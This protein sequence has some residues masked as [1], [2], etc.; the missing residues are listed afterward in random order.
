MRTVEYLVALFMSLILV[1]NANAQIV[2]RDNI[3]KNRKIVWGVNITTSADN[4]FYAVQPSLVISFEK[5]IFLIGP[6]FTFH[7]DV[8]TDN[9]V[10]GFAFSYKRFPNAQNKHLDFYFI[11]DIGYT[12]NKH[13]EKQ[14]Y[15]DN[16]ILYSSN[17]KHSLNYWGFTLGYGFV[18]KMK[19]FYID[20]NIALGIGLYSEE[21]QLNVPDFP[22]ASYNEKVTSGLGFAKLYKI[23]IGYNF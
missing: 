23:G 8:T 7:S 4:Y 5:N 21:Y 14:N 15:I 3:E 16:G 22:T 18:Y 19:N 1:I 20:Q 10:D 6:K 11:S 2:K 12:T 9:F 17:Y 13:S